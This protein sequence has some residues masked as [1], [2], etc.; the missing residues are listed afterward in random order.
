MCVKRFIAD[1]MGAWLLKLKNKTTRQLDGFRRSGQP[2][3]AE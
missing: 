3:G 1:A 2:V